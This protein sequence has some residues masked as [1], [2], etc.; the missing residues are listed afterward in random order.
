MSRSS[1]LIVAGLLVVLLS[2]I[3][4]PLAWLHVLLPAL[5]IVVV[6]IGFLIRTDQV[7]KARLSTP[8]PPSPNDISAIA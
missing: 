6:S 5:G 8:P 2:F 4:L 3:G 1:T 7:K